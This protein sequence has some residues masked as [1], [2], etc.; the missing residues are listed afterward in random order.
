MVFGDH[1]HWL[2]R[3]MRWNGPIEVKIQKALWSNE[4]E[5]R[6]FIHR[7]RRQGSRISAERL[8]S[9]GDAAKRKTRLS[10]GHPPPQGSEKPI[11]LP[12]NFS[13]GH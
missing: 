5:R 11:L 3:A 9:R 8:E 12:A 6:S 10:I 7:L 2:S 4:V 1:L 13:I